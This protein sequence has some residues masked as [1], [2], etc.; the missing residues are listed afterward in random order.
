M[1]DLT[2]RNCDAKLSLIAANQLV[3]NFELKAHSV[4]NITNSC[5]SFSRLNRRI[6]F[7]ALIDDTLHKKE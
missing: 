2:A 4:E 6:S 7:A 1:T 3:I 5:Y